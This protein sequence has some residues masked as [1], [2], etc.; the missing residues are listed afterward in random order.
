MCSI[1]QADIGTYKEHGKLGSMDGMVELLMRMTF[2]ESVTRFES[3]QFATSDARL[4]LLNYIIGSREQIT[5]L[6]WSETSPIA[7][8][9]S[10]RIF[11][12]D[13]LKLFSS[14]KL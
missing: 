11:M 2:H 8:A 6:R 4:Q 14:V 10:S 12:N 5:A 9:R 1:L 13:S 3:D 7:T